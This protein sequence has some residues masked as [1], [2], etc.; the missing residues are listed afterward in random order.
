M[1]NME[2]I[3]ISIKSVCMQHRLVGKI[4][5]LFKQKGFHF[6]AMVFLQASEE[7]ALQ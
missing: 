1:A 2:H 5:K 4:I 3:F 6:V 7:A